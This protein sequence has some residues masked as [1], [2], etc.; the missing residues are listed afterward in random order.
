VRS[1]NN[2]S[3]LAVGGVTLFVI[4]RRRRARRVAMLVNE[5]GDFH[6]FDEIVKYRRRFGHVAEYRVVERHRVY[7]FGTLATWYLGA[8]LRE[9]LADFQERFCQS[10]REG[11]HRGRRAERV[12]RRCRHSL[13]L[14]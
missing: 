5:G 3:V 10:R 9:H 11:I 13:S 1:E 4:C 2:G 14:F 8:M 7:R 12:G 6:F